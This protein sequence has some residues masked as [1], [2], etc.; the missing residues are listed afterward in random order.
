MAPA[1]AT[2]PSYVSSAIGRFFLR[3]LFRFHIG[4]DD[5]LGNKLEALGFALS[6]VCRVVV[7]HLHWDH[8]GGIAEV[9]R[10]DLLV[11]EDEWRQLS[12]PHPE[13]EWIFR[14][15]IELPGAKWRPIAFKPTA[16]P[17]FAPFGGCY[18][19]MGDGS[20]TLLPTPGHTPGSMSMLVQSS[21]LPPLLLV[22]DL[23]YATVSLMKD[24]VPGTGNA[25]QLRSS[26]AKVRALKKQLPGLLI[27]PAHDPEATKAL[28]A[29]TQNADGR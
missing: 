28:K 11:S 9:P 5:R 27:L 6:D 17:L 29:A 8:I 4:P 13:R 20:M 25:Q 24:Q 19:V 26:F 1:I 3:R 21:G 23:T 15:H 12:G 14:E 16:N 10:A 18:D 22:G 7:S 2:D